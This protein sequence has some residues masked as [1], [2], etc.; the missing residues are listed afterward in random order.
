[1]LRLCFLPGWNECQINNG[2][3][4]HLCIAHT[5]IFRGLRPDN[6]VCPSRRDLEGTNITCQCP[7]H[8]ACPTHYALSPD[9]VTCQSRCYWSCL[10]TCGLYLSGLIWP[11]LIPFV[12]FSISKEQLCMYMHFLWLIWLPG[13]VSEFHSD[14]VRL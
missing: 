2:G 3:C 10:L 9:G 1:M 8:C 12:I 7:L 11:S 4:S 13:L 5:P 14:L 6:C